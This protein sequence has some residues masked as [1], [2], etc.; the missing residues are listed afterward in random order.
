MKASRVLKHFLVNRLTDGGEVVSL[1]CRPSFAQARFLVLISV[2]AGRIGPIKKC[3]DVF[4]N[5]TR[6]LPAEGNGHWRNI[7]L[8]T[9][10]RLYTSTEAGCMQKRDLQRCTCNIL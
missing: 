4:D 6:D 3:N 8:E 7:F 5:G 1:T 2:R 10:I 9:G